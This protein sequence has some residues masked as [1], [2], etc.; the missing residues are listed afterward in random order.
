MSAY[1]YD[2]YA[3][4]DGGI[5]HAVVNEYGAFDEN[6]DM[7]NAIAFIRQVIE[8]VSVTVDYDSQS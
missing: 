1:H 7:S 4:I 2:I 8:T 5:F 3:E 6:Y